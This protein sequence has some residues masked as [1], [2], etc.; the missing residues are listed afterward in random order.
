SQRS[1]ASEGSGPALLEIAT[2]RL[3]ELATARAVT[4]YVP[5]PGEPDVGPLVA[6]LHERGVVVLLP[7]MR[8][9]NELDWVVHDPAGGPT[10]GAV[11]DASV[12]LVPALAVDRSG[13]R[14]G[15]G[16]G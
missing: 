15:R 4:A 1:A 6:A 10:R 14:L 3:P 9:G 5:L 8:P 7:V 2:R 11:D 13:H 16:G 12:L